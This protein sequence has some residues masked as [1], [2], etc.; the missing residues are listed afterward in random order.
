MKHV[1]KRQELQTK[2]DIWNAVMTI[3]SEI[4]FP[5]DDEMIN[6]T[7]IVFQYYSELESGGHESLLNWLSSYIE[8]VGIEHYLNEL[9]TALEKV[10]AQEYAHIEME[11][12]EEMWRL[13][14]A[15]ENGDIEE[16]DFYNVI[17]KANDAYEKLDGKLES[18]LESYFMSIYTDLINV[19]D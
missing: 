12:G 5:T 4:D 8:E 19:V 16:K 15:L 3:M 11:Y 10:G 7:F 2:E 18:T 14:T 17:E 6:Q 9:T 13:F 1:M